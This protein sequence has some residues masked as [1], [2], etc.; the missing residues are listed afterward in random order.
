MF[1]RW[2]TQVAL[3]V[4]A[5]SL[6]GW[7]YADDV[8]LPPLVARGS[9]GPKDVANITQLLASELDF[10]PAVDSVSSLDTPAGYGVRCVADAACMRRIGQRASATHV[11]GG[12]L[13]MSD[14]K[15]T[16]ELS[17]LSVK[18]GRFVRKQTFEF[19]NRP[20]DVAD[21]MGAVTREM[22]T[23]EKPKQETASDDID[24]NDFDE[25]FEFDFDESDFEEARALDEQRKRE[26][27]AK[28]E[29]RQAQ[30]EREA[31]LAE[32]RR[33]EEAR[34]QAEEERRRAEEA[35]RQ[36]EE[37]R[38]RA[39]E[40][41]RQAELEDQRRRAEAERRLAEEEQRRAEEEDSSAAGEDEF[42]PD[43]FSFG[44]STIVVEGEDDDEPILED[45]PDD[46]DIEDEP[47]R[48]VERKPKPESRPREIREPRV[49]PDRERS[50]FKGQQT[51]TEFALRGGVS[52][53]YSLNFIAAG[54]E[55]AVSNGE[56]PVYGTVGIALYAAQRSIPEAFRP[57]PLETTAW[58]FI[59]PVNTGVLYKPSLAN[60]R[61]KPYG[62][63]DVVFVRYYM[64][65]EGGVGSVA[66]GG[67][68]R[69]GVDVMITPNVGVNLDVA[70]GGWFGKDWVIIEPNMKNAGM[71][72]QGSAGLVVGF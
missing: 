51:T 25:D 32:Q 36:A 4:G 43:A 52:S 1:F 7:A 26:A 38:R 72:P 12:T 56:V 9:T 59:F 5:V 49:R 6:S 3:L 42:D 10:M 11:L 22:V 66:I 30:A 53:Y 35:R 68:A 24:L 21:G 40:A 19:P 29:A 54:A 27:R 13:N 48:A 69:A 58:N 18:T 31:A 61:V 2:T 15:V 64:G 55:V 14:T 67:R 20:E 63:A 16:L 28:E 17:Y 47:R 70:A 23:G 8:A 34:R 33:I 37:E 62:G 39:E 71:V 41:R 50:G 44:S 65:P 46:L 57:S 60:G 45:D